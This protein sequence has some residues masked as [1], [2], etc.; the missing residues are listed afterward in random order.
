MKGL[1]LWGFIKRRKLPGGACHG[2]AD[3]V[4]AGGV[5]ETD[6]SAMSCNRNGIDVGVELEERW[7]IEGF[8]IP[9]GGVEDDP[10]VEVGINHKKPGVPGGDLGTC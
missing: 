4:V 5:A 2:V 6:Q 9:F 8:P 3:N 10:L 1:I 7:V